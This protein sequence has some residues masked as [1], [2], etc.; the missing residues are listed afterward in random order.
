M[1]IKIQQ[2][3]ETMNKE[4]VYRFQFNAFWINTVI[5]K[6]KNKELVIFQSKPMRNII[7]ADYIDHDTDSSS[8]GYR[9]RDDFAPRFGMVDCD[10]DNFVNIEF[11]CANR[12][13]NVTKSMWERRV[14]PKPYQYP[15]LFN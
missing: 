7:I 12:A 6:I 11:V 3:Q 1:L 5:K 14:H 15:V 8:D 13:D 9:L 4:T 10:H 2:N